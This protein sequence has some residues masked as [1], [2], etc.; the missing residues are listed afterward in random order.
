MLILCIIIASI[1]FYVIVQI[2]FEHVL[3]KHRVYLVKRLGIYN[4][5]DA[6]TYSWTWVLFLPIAIVLLLTHD[7]YARL[8]KYVLKGNG[9]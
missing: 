1:F 4:E 2:V 6:K 8:K 9:L 3:L 5:G 7:F